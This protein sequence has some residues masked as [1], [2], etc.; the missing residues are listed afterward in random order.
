MPSSG[1][2]DSSRD[3]IFNAVYIANSFHGRL[4]ETKTKHNTDEPYINLHLR[5]EGVFNSAA[6]ARVA[7]RMGELQLLTVFAHKNFWDR[8]YCT[9][10]SE[11]FELQLNSR[12]LHQQKL[13]KVQLSRNFSTFQPANVLD[14]PNVEQM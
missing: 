14:L 12:F 6:T 9:L 10:C 7:V 8:T 13:T 3:R 11:V 2:S 1:V 4:F 5:A